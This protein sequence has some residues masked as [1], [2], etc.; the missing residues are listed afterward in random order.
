M[1]PYIFIIIILL[2][3]AI[4]EVFGIKKNAKIYFVMSASIIA[5]FAGLR[6]K[7]G[8]D[9]SIY[10]PSFYEMPK[11]GNIEN[12]E[13]GYY[14]INLVFYHVF[15][16]YYVLQFV[17]S[18]FLLYSVAKFF[19]RFTDYPM[20]SLLLFF[21]IFI[22]NDILMAQVR[23]SVALAI[24]LFSYEYILNKSLGKFVLIV[25]LACLFHISA[26]VVLP[27][28]FM[29]KIIPNYILIVLVLLFQI[30]YFVPE[31]T[32]YIV[33]FFLPYM[34]DR[35]ERIGNIY[36]NDVLF[37]GKSEFNTGLYYIA[38]VLLSVIV[39]YFIS[40]K[41]ERKSF[42][43]NSLAIA[44]I[45]DALSTSMF[46]LG[47]FQA[48]Y[49]IFAVSAYSLMFNIKIRW[50]TQKTS[51]LIIMLL[52][53]SFFYVQ[54]HLRLTSN[55]EETSVSS[56]TINENSLNPYYN[57]IYHPEEADFRKDWTEE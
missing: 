31:T 10:V 7:T 17:A 44:M 42:L 20:M 3:G 38:G 32:A 36:V 45:I 11:L 33:K 34:P 29:T 48:Y 30:F 27:M 4:A 25:I 46:I 57:V 6:Y 8:A 52:L 56:S 50:I 9:W 51:N 14:W 26:L 47:R 18:V 16:N 13:V 35:L 21:M 40:D 53:F 54:L 43:L 12:W 2:I 37:G 24:L 39:I 23:Q 41:D 28:Y 49:L 5:I 55:K 19:W 15:G 22:Y 1:F